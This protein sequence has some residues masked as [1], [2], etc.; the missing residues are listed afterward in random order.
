MIMRMDW[1]AY[2]DESESDQTVDPNVYVLA[3]ALI[4]PNNC[5]DVRSLMRAIHPGRGKLHWHDESAPERRKIVAAVAEL[6]VLHLVVVR[7][8]MPG[9]HPER[10]RRKCLE[11]LLFELEVRQVGHAVF[12]ARQAKQN[13]RDRH[14]ADQLRARK[15]LPA[16]LRIDHAPG[17]IE[18]LL[19]LADVGAGVVGGTSRRAYLPAT[20]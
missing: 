8:G 12:E 7:Q 5:E 10:R 13:E 4:H 3:A 15:L 18:P 1:T 9:G 20:T 14:L 17:P 19:W 6:D 11:R 16:R 2:V